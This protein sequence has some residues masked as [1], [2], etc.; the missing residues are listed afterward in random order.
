M[1]AIIDFLNIALACL[2]V[3]ACVDAA[4]HARRSIER[5]LAGVKAVIAMWFLAVQSSWLMSA[6]AGLSFETVF[7]AYG[8]DV[9]N[10]ATMATFMVGAWINRHR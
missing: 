5:K 10:C 2:A 9:F 1:R 8:W 6:A 4:R 7:A 3:L